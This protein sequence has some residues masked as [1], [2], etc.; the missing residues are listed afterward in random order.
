M[1]KAGISPA[2]MARRIG[3][4]PGALTVLWRT[5]TRESRL[6]PGIHRELG[7]PAPSTV[8]SADEVLRRINARWSLL[9][10]EQRVLVDDLV[11]QLAGN[12]RHRDKP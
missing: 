3:C 2:E 11:E 4:T 5:E 6:V 7:R 12:R 1:A 8:S 10:P 9:S